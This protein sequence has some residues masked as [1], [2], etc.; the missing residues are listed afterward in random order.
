MIRGVRLP[1]RQVPAA[2]RALSAQRLLLR[3]LA[4]S[5]LVVVLALVRRG[6]RRARAQGR[7]QDPRH[8]HR[9]PRRPGA[10]PDHRAARP[11]RSPRTRSSRRLSRI[12]PGPSRGQPV[13]VL[14]DGRKI[15]VTRLARRGGQVL[16]HHRARRGASRSRRTRSSRRRSRASRASPPAAPAP[17]RSPRPHQ[18][19]HPRPRPEPAPDAP[20]PAAAAATAQ[21]PPRTL[22]AAAR[23]LVDRLPG[24]SADREGPHR[25]SLQPER[26]E[27]RQAGDRRPVFLVLTGVARQ[28]RASCGG[29]PWAAASAPRTRRARVLR[30]RRPVL[31]E[32]ARVGLRRAVPRP[33]RVQS[34]RA[35]P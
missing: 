1:W 18:P 2:P 15:P 26:A 9:P 16:V 35:G 10:L 33:D 19:S 34:P 4:W 3:V 30:R 20:P 8:P 24:R 12:H 31:H 14:K 25:R 13:L 32:P 23:P 29:C 22:H 27:G 5:L 28:R 7:P 6:G 11:S 21:R 17:P